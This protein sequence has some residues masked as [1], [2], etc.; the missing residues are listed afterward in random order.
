MDYKTI[1]C[2]MYVNGSK[3]AQER[4][5]AERIAMK[6]YRLGAHYFI[7]PIFVPCY[8]WI[9]TIIFPKYTKEDYLN[10]EKMYTRIFNYVCKMVAKVCVFLCGGYWLKEKRKVCLNYD[11]T[12]RPCTI[13]DKKQDPRCTHIIDD[14]I[15]IKK[16]GE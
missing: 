6:A 14:M 7:N 13:D 5:K 8:N 10:K 2:R 16:F 1:M 15:S 9:W 3:N 11:Y 4:K 12:I